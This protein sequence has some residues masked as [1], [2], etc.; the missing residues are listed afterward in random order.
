MPCPRRADHLGFAKAV[1]FSVVEISNSYQAAV[2][3]AKRLF[4]RGTAGVIKKEDET[5]GANQKYLASPEYV[6]V[7]LCDPADNV[8]T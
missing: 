5:E 6:A 2:S 4:T 7:T 8:F 1:R 3:L